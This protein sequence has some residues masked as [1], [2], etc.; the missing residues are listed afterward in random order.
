MALAAVSALA[1]LPSSS[2]AWS[3]SVDALLAKFEPDATD[4]T[5]TVGLTPLTGYNLSYAYTSK[6][7]TFAVVAD[8]S[9]WIGLGIGE[10]AGMRG[11][12]IMMGHFDGSTG[13]AVVGDYHSSKNG[14]P[15]RDGCQDWSV[16]HGEEK[17]G[18]T[19]LV[20]SRS[21]STQDSNDHPILLESIKRLTLL[22]AYGTGDDYSS[23]AMHST[24]ARTKYPIDLSSGGSVNQKSWRAEKMNDANIMTIDL[25]AAGQSET[26]AVTKQISGLSNS[27]PP[28]PG[29]HPLPTTR[30]AYHE[31]CYPVSENSAWTQAFRDGK[32]MVAFEGVEDPEGRTSD[33]NNI[34]HTVLYAYTE[35]NCAGDDY[36]IIWVGGVSFYEDLPPGVGISMSRFKAFRLQVHYDNPA[37]TAGLKDDSGVRVY[38]TSTQPPKEAG[39]LQLGDGTIQLENTVIPKGRSYYD[40]T[41]TGNETSKWPIESIT[42]FGSILHMHATGDMMYTE[43]LK[44][45]GT[46][47]K[48]VNSVQYF[49]FDHQDPTLITPYQVHRG[50]TLKTRCYFNNPGTQEPLTFG[51]GSEQEMCIDFLYY[52]P[53]NA[54]IKP[55]CTFGHGEHFG[56]IFDGRTIITDKSDPGMRAFGVNVGT[57]DDP[58]CVVAL[59]RC[60]TARG[61]EFKIRAPSCRLIYLHCELHNNCIERFED[62]IFVNIES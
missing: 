38:L 58:T 3:S 28:A 27:Q 10:A 53:Y 33:P 25:R 48:K 57:E 32:W 42:V 51:L 14:K 20:F 1:L 5:T 44:A 60:G 24:K 21:L 31:F 37:G 4:A 19:L 56:G 2:A 41:C 47:R 8:T 13:K 26:G 45:D 22:C 29:G 46:P 40:F 30:T 9:G 12:D 43:I 6:H 34:H 39:T 35:D 36:S 7:I 23:Y 11:A 18:K 15:T 54:G 62:K 16:H 49:D 55:H 61:A 52:Y 50:D 17:D 59:W